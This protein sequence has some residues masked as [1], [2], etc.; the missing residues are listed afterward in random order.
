MRIGIVISAIMMAFLLTA[1]AKQVTAGTDID[2]SGEAV[3]VKL[4]EKAAPQSSA[5]EIFC[6]DGTNAIR[7]IVFDEAWKDKVIDAVNS[8]NL[9][10]A[11]ENALSGWKEPCYGISMGDTDGMEIWLTYA[12]GLWIEKGGALYRGELD[13]A[14]YFDEAASLDRTFDYTSQSGI[15]IPNAA[16]LAKYSIKYCQ[17]ATGEEV[18]E[19]DG[20]SLRFVSLDGS[21][22]TVE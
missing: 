15:S 1:C 16:I 6:F 4:L 21:K 13:L 12:N 20:V 9:K 3:D 22:V 5:L 17:K 11:D 2:H 14:A 19:K 8:L 7:R 10:L 18:T